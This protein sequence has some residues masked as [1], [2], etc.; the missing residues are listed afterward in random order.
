M[1]MSSGRSLRRE[2]RLPEM[3]W[4]GVY[5][6]NRVWPYRLASG[7]GDLKMSDQFVTIQGIKVPWVGANCSDSWEMSDNL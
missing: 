2:T 5:M 4:G 3:G 6:K 1:R 7:G